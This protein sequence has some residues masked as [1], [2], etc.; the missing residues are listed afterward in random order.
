M[1]PLTPSQAAMRRVISPPHPPLSPPPPL[2]RRRCRRLRKHPAAVG[3]FCSLGLDP[4]LECCAALEDA[5]ASAAAVAADRL[6]W[7]TLPW[8]SSSDSDD[9]A[10]PW[11]EPAQEWP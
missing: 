1:A 11:C 8:L 6:E 2:L 10:A 4:G 5:A 3:A 7:F 9:W